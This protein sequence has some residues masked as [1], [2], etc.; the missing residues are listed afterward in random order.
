MRS[1]KNAGFV[2]L[3]ALAIGCEI[4]VEDNM[5]KE[6]SI[7]KVPPAFE[8]RP[9]EVGVGIKGKSLENE[10]G[11]GLAI[12]QPA[13][14]LFRM[15]EKIPF[16][17]EIPHA[18]ELYKASEGHA[19]QTHE[20]FMEKIV[21]FNNIKLPKLPEGQEYRYRPEDAQLWVQP[22]KTP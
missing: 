6:K 15:K 10:T 1:S 12:A 5:T 9:A 17:I 2:F 16:E 4:P 14:V 19:P 20:E 22:I 7:A 13:M 18:L 21:K 11:I 8:A 3:A